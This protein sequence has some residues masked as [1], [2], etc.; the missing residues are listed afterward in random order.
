MQIVLA[1][2]IDT[3]NVLLNTR[4]RRLGY[5]LLK[6]ASFAH[7]ESDKADLIDS[8]M[9]CHLLKHVKV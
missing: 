9:R 2:Q 8:F 3:N 6:K 5:T 7:F 1:T 4:T